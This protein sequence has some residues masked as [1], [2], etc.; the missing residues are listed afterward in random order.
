MFGEVPDSPWFSWGF[1]TVELPFWGF[2]VLGFGGP[3]NKEDILWGCTLGV[4]LFRETTIH[5][6]G[7]DS[8]LVHL[9]M[10]AMLTAANTNTGT[11]CMRAT[12]SSIQLGRC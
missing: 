10:I 5:R 2:R 9:K 1:P 6:L 3:D 7:G 12:A 4:L 11:F 8:Q